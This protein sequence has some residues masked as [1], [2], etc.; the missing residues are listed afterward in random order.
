[1]QEHILDFSLDVI[2]PI[3]STLKEYNVSKGK[4]YQHLSNEA[5]KLKEASLFKNEEIITTEQAASIKTTKQDKMLNFCANNY[6]GLSAHPEL[7][8]AAKAAI[9]Q[10]GYG[11]SSVR[12][13]CGTQTP[14]KELEERLS[15]FMGTEE[16]ILYP[17]CFDAN[18]GLFETILGPEDAIISDQLNHASIIDGIRLCKAKRYRYKNND[19]EDLE[20]QLKQ[21]KEDNARFILIVSDGV[22]SMD[23]II[24]NLPGIVALAEKYEALTMIDDCHAT[25]FMGKT[26][27][28]THEYYDLVGKID[29]ITST[30][31]KALG[32]ASGGFTAGKKEIITMLR[33]KSRPYL[34]SNSIAPVIAATSLKAL[35][36][37]NSNSSLIEKLHEN[38]R[39]FRNEM[40]NEGFDII[41]G[42]HPIVPVMFYD[43]KI[44]SA[45]SNELLRLGIYAIA[46]S[47]P[48]VPM[49]TARI[50]VQMSAA[51]TKEHLDKAIDAFKQ[52]RENLKD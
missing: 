20:K 52:A 48:V 31:G 47:Y 9:D 28:G 23:G 43:A 29:I 15:R 36:L 38:T 51:H 40:S 14:H 7:K 24:A 8:T 16:V 22:F 35:D 49:D 42:N 2:Q 11:L 34:F 41:T 50:R 4:F 30:L 45:M 37:V 33:Q 21:A 6:L 10:Y 46:F 3:V 44:A 19:M 5:N 27:R 12:F 32:G 1:M 18:G 13:I 17:S 25:G 39:Y 26:G